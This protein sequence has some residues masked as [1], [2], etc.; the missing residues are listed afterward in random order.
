LLVQ[1]RAGRAAGS[2][3]G[4]PVCLREH[5]YS[6]SG[7]PL[8]HLLQAAA[9]IPDWL[10]G[11]HTEDLNDGLSSSASGALSLSIKIREHESLPGSRSQVRRRDWRRNWI[12]EYA[13]G[14]QKRAGNI[15]G[16]QGTSLDLT[17]HKVVRIRD[18]PDSIQAPKMPLH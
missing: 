11:R 4:K 10:C 7:G 2:F 9:G 1:R 8:P 15:V 12:S 18:R 3:A 5:R 13:V 6:I 16:F 17:E 14:D